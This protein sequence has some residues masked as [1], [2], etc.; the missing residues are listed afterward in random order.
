MALSKVTFWTSKEPRKAHCTKY[1]F[2]LVRI[3][4]CCGMRFLRHAFL[5]IILCKFTPHE[6]LALVIKIF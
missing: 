5:V 3:L 6:A 2:S 4:I 1:K